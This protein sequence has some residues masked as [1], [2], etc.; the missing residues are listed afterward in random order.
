[1][2]EEVS[3]DENE[4][5]EVKA[6]MALASKERNFVSKELTLLNEDTSSNSGLKDPM[7]VKSSADNS[8]VSITD[9]NKSKLSEAEDSTLS[10]H[11]TGKLM[12]LQSVA[13]LSSTR[14]A[15][16]C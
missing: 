7:F 3:S 6:L 14:E 2:E 15:D 11:D 10:N 9:S 13:P 16:S 12:N 1:M 5:T 4:V 8:E